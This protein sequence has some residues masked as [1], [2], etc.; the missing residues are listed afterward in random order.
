MCICRV[1]EVAVYECVSVKQNRRKGTFF[2]LRRTNDLVILPEALGPTDPD[3]ATS[4]PVF[5]SR[6]QRAFLHTL[7]NRGAY[8]LPEALH[9]C[10]GEW[11]SE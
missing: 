4:R 8:L 9:E 5:S 10:V 11:V 2:G 1:C 7:L 6:S 3:G